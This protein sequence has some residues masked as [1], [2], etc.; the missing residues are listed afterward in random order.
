MGQALN[1]P[2]SP[3]PAEEQGGA[4]GV[5]RRRVGWP[6]PSSAGS[7][8]G[9]V[10][11]PV[12]IP[13]WPPPTP[14]GGMGRGSPKIRP[15]PHLQWPQPPP[16]SLLAPKVQRVTLT[17]PGSHTHTRCRGFWFLFFKKH[18]YKKKKDISE[19]EG[20]GEETWLM[21]GLAGWG[22]GQPP[23]GAGAQRG[24]SAG[25]APAGTHSACLARARTR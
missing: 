5:G 4:P 9:Q 12:L 13:T 3:L 17:S 22:W 11:K 20:G 14:V 10:Q 8:R 1:T 21:S 2:T 16:S 6:S 25:R 18:V 23:G 19:T 24:G 7:K 15:L